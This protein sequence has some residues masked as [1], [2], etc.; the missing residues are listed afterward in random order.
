MS[1][2]LKRKGCVIHRYMYIHI[3][4]YIQKTEA[5]IVNGMKGANSCLLQAVKAF[6][7]HRYSVRELCHRQKSKSSCCSKCKE[8]RVQ[9]FRSPCLGS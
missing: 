8:E 5:N 2:Y 7:H 3:C 4:V 1:S 6:F 9:R